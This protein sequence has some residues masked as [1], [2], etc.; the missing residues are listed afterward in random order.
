MHLPSLQSVPR[1][2]E[3]CPDSL[4]KRP[5]AVKEGKGLFTGYTSCLTLRK[6]ET[7]SLQ[8]LSLI[9]TEFLGIQSPVCIPARKDIYANNNSVHSIRI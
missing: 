3:V 4:E 8:H 6:R 1:G 2:R 5:S 9:C 7:N